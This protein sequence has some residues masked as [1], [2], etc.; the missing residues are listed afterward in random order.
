MFLF[1]KSKQIILNSWGFYLSF[2][3]FFNL[4]VLVYSPS[5]LGRHSSRTLRNLSTLCSQSEESSKCM[6]V[7]QLSAS[8]R[9]GFP[10]LNNSVRKISQKHA[11][12]LI[13]QMILNFVKLTVNTIIS[14]HRKKTKIW[15]NLIPYRN[16]FIRRNIILNTQ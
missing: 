13:S 5:V 3:F 16:F 15:S 11:Q 7:A 6:L 14:F 9:V 12:R 8:F 2:F 1:L 10:I 4:P